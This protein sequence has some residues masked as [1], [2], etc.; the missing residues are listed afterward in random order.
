[1]NQLEER[2]DAPRFS[3]SV[4]LKQHVEGESHPCCATEVSSTGLYMERPAAGFVRHSTRV[5][6]EIA[7][8]D[9]EA[10]VWTDAEIVYD[11]FDALSHGTAVRFVSM[12]ASDRHRL[13]GWLAAQ[14]NRAA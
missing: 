10:P 1:M 11:C 13:H 3:V 5:Q 12:S 14:A 7:L 8:C 9:G 2:R 6:L 4:P